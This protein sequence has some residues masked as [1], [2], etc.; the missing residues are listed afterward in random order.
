MKKRWKI[1]WIVCACMG[2]IGA[3]CLLISFS[4]GVTIEAIEQ[5]FPNGISI[6]K[7]EV[8]ND[9]VEAEDTDAHHIYED[10]NE[11]DIEL[12]AGELEIYVSDQPQIELVT[13]RI[14]EKLKLK[15]YRD[16]DT[17]VIDSSDIS[18]NIIGNL[19][20]VSL[21]LPE[22]V[23]FAEASISVGAG[24][25]YIE[26]IRAKELSVDVGTG[27]AVIDSFEAKEADFDC[28]AGEL[29]ACGNVEKLVDIDCGMG[30]VDYTTYDREIDYNYNLSCGV[31]NIECGSHSCSGIGSDQ[32]LDNHA[33]KTMDIDCGIG[34]V[35]ISF[36]GEMT[37][38]EFEYEEHMEDEE[39]HF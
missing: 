4:M 11:L 3:A 31:G 13:E 23:V 18:G 14:S 7:F 33:S 16:N 37:E 24:T 20:T 6:G 30:K 28:G 25:L 29:T 8:E 5:R 2:V 32:K 1:F 35:T 9:G 39:H 10:I 26:D 12:T 27:E 17:L 38:E 36:E 19:G 22:N 15:C 21:Y 34:E